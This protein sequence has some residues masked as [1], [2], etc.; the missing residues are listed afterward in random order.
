MNQLNKYFAIWMVFLHIDILFTALVITYSN[1]IEANI[2]PAF[3]LEHFG[4]LGLYISTII[5]AY[6]IYLIIERWKWKHSPKMF[7]IFSLLN[8][9]SFVLTF[10]N[11]LYFEGI[12]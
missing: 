4:I 8:I 1:F 3:I 5:I 2:I 7:L 10:L 11:W 9:S 12:I 6:I